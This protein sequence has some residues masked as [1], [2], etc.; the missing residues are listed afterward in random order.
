MG[1]LI[2]GHNLALQLLDFLPAEG[3]QEP[4]EVVAT[5]VSPELVDAVA[6]AAEKAILWGGDWHGSAFWKG[7][8]SQSEADM[9]L[10][11]DIGRIAIRQNVPHEMLADIM[12]TVFKRS[13]LYR[14]DKIR[15][16]KQHTIPKLIASIQA[17]A[18]DTPNGTDDEPLPRLALHEGLIEF[19]DEP[20]PPREF[21]LEDLILAVKVCVLAGLGGV[22]KTMWMMMLAVCVAL[23]EPFM[24]KLTKAGAVLLILGEEDAEEIWRRFGAIAVMRGLTQEQIAL[25]KRRVRAFPMNGLDAR[26]TQVTGGSLE[27]TAFASEIIAAS[28]E[29]EAVAGVPVVLIGLDHAGLVHGGEFNSREDVVQTMRQVNYI[30]QQAKAAVMVLAHSPKTSVGKDASDSNDVAGSAAWVDL[31]RAVF[32]LRAMTEAEGRE[33]GFTTEL[34]SQYVSLSVV[35]SNYGPSGG[36][37]WLRRKTIDSH[38]VGVLLQVELN[39]PAP[40]SKGGDLV[41]ARVLEFIKG[42]PGRYSKTG[43][44]DTHSGKDGPFKASKNDVSAALGNLVSAAKIV[45]REP[46]SEERKVFGLSRQ[47]TQVMEVSKCV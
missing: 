28:N 8:Q 15:S 26:L 14:A 18:E 9:A 41:Q 16:I 25:V 6:K 30:A 39:K 20:P 38:G 40:A 11:G 13:G 42:N 10:L 35:K 29:L 21:V 44:R 12:F 43:L 46:T 37:Y 34:R 22:S 32:V 33:F 5:N 27:G 17:E 4:I 31:A 23:G 1:S 45:M 2:D 47:I 36:K 7:Y 3:K 24:G 19:S